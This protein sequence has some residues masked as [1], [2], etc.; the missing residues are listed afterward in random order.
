[1]ADRGHELALQAV[2]LAPLGDVHETARDPSPLRRLELEEGELERKHLAVLAA[3]FPLRD[4]PHRLPERI[5]KEGAD[6][7][8]LPLRDERAERLADQLALLVAED[9]LRRRIRELDASL[10]PHHDEASQHVL[11]EGPRPGLAG[12]ERVD[13]PPAL[14]HVDERAFDEARR[15]VRVPHEVHAREHP[16]RRP[17]GP[18]DEELLAH[19]ALVGDQAVH[20]S[21]PVARVLVE[22]RRATLE[23]L[24]ARRK[25]EE[26]QKGVVALE[27]LPVQRAP[28]D[29]RLVALE[30]KA[31][32]LLGFP[33]MA[34]RPPLRLLHADA[35]VRHEE[36]G[37]R[38]DEEKHEGS[39]RDLSA[40]APLGG[41]DLPGLDE[42]DELPF[43]AAV[44]ARRAADEGPGENRPECEGSRETS[45][46][47][48]SP[49]P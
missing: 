28:V 17:V 5:P 49:L 4:P 2:D 21:R 33:E 10:V 14:V 43:L 15:A 29:A 9:P 31:V 27:Q 3:P 32:A 7:D 38:D 42:G 24:F 30:E 35:L 18:F 41:D 6:S 39:D 11:E 37:G 48:R 20:E 45:G 1:M 40:E 44:Q 8:V 36:D 23:G 25:A 46:A 22:G 34:Q 26:P 12:A 16:S 47:S 13:R 19:G